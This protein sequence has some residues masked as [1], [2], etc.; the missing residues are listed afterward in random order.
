MKPSDFNID[1][2]QKE[3][4]NLLHCQEVI[5][6]MIEKLLGFIKKLQVLI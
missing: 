1:I 5:E 2:G 6:H 3:Y 4:F